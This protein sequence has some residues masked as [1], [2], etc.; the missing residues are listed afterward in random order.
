M[1]AVLTAGLP[2]GPQMVTAALDAYIEVVDYWCTEADHLA[3][4]AQL[5][6]MTN[7]ADPVI[8]SA[9][10]ICML[11]GISCALNEPTTINQQLARD[12]RQPS[13]RHP[14]RRHHRHLS[15][16]AAEAHRPGGAGLAD[17]QSRQLMPRNGSTSAW[18]RLRAQVL[19]EE[20]SCW[21]QLPGCTHIA[22]EVDHVIPYSQAPDLDMV[23][24]NLRGV[25][26]SCNRKRG[27]ASARD[28]A[29]RRPAALRFFDQ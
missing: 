21:L 26:R 13:H 12:S 20:P 1:P 10:A 19:A 22:D 18:R 11:H 27:N 6:Q 2:R 8:R 3:L 24:S 14:V 15:R 7:H 5:D 25:C 4:V 9:A 28:V 16:L 23:R 29:P 17:S